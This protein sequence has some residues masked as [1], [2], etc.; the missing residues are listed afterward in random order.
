MAMR[1]PRSLRHAAASR[2]V[3]SEPLSAMRHQGFDDLLADRED[4]IECAHRFLEDHAYVAATDPAHLPARQPDKIAAVEEYA[5]LHAAGT[6]RQET[7]D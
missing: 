4:R 5:A 2:R 6:A 3:R 1:L 7:K